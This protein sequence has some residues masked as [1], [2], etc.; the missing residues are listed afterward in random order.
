M[1]HLIIVFFLLTGGWQTLFSQV[2][3]FE[4]GIFGGVALYSGDL[5]PQSFGIYPTDAQPAFGL[6]VRLNLQPWLTARMAYGK[7]NLYSR[8]AQA[9]RGLEFRSRLE[10][11]TLVA[12][13]QPWRFEIGN[14]QLVPY[15]CAGI[16]YFRFNPEARYQGDWIALQPLGTE[17]QLLPDGPG[18]YSLQEIN[19]PL[20]IGVKWILSDKIVVALEL[21]GRKLLTDFLDDISD[22]LV[23]YRELYEFNGPV[24]AQMSRPS[25]SGPDDPELI[26]YRRGGSFNDWYYLSGLS[27]AYRFQGRPSRPGQGGKSTDCYRF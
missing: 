5:S 1:K 7:G 24:T 4:P 23:D 26:P 11:F 25:V 12:E 8:D 15:L 27:I 19:I 3:T 22:T 9:Q 16:G 6:L 20:G 18:P 17:G 10:E 14:Q 21:G 13:V 2:V